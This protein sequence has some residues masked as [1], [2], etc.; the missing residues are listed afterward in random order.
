MTLGRA[1]VQ[2]LTIVH[3]Q[4]LFLASSWYFCSRER[5]FLLPKALSFKRLVHFQVWTLHLSSTDNNDYCCWDILLYCSYT[6]PHNSPLSKLVF[7]WQ[8]QW[9]V[10]KSV[11]MLSRE[12]LH[13]PKDLDLRNIG[14]TEEEYPEFRILAF[15]PKEAKGCCISPAVIYDSRSLVTYASYNT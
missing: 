2:T 12:L 11:E 15:R 5:I 9:W 13:W 7:Y 8:W 6:K 4:V 3:K 1:P 10:D 14:G